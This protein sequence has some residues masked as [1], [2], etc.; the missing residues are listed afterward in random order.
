MLDALRR[1][2]ALAICPA[3]A[4]LPHD[5]SFDVPRRKPRSANEQRWAEN[6]RRMDRIYAAHTG[7]VL[8]RRNAPAYDGPL[9]QCAHFAEF[10]Q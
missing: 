4:S 2:V 8:D 7:V 1:R 10:G 5:P 3:L 6:L 9:Y